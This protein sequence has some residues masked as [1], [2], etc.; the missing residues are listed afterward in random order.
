MRNKNTQRSIQIAKM[1]IKKKE[2]HYKNINGVITFN[3]NTANSALHLVTIKTPRSQV[4]HA[5][6]EM[7]TLPNHSIS[8]L[9]WLM[10]SLNLCRLV[11]SNFPFYI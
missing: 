3:D 7:L 2:I 9:K 10:F 4:P 5:E 8:S 6:Q 1:S 11:F